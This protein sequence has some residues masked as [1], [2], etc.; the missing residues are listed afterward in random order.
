MKKG[1]AFPP[2]SFKTSL[3]GKGINMFRAL[4]RKHKE[5]PRDICVEVL[6]T[7]TRG[8]LSVI[9]EEGYPY[10]MPMNHWYNEED[11]AIYFHCGDARSHRMDALQKDNRVSFCVYDQGYRKEGDW[12][13]YVKSV[14]VFGK[15]EVIDDRE[16]IRAISTKLSYKFTNDTAF[17]E[18]TIRDHLHRTR[19]L[20]LVPEHICGKLVHEQ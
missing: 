2:F 16:V 14:I 9:G 10:G 11:G 6:K 12:S 17:I 5:L 4:E 3:F 1:G 20:K 15:M 19:L 8:V 7:E 18:G 13:Y